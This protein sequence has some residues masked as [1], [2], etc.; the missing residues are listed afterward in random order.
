[1]FKFSEWLKNKEINEA[2]L[3]PNVPQT[4]RAKPAQQP[5]MGQAQQ[6]T[7]PQAQ[8]QA[9]PQQVSLSQYAP[10]MK[11]PTWHFLYD[12]FTQAYQ[13]HPQDPKISQLGT[14]LY[15]AAQSGNMAGLQP[16]R[17]QYGLAAQRMS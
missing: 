2:G 1:M 5:A 12:A 8:Q 16:F 4:Q 14:A 9:Q 15:Q 6:Q 7:Q 10:K 13:K 3:F 11:D 17:S